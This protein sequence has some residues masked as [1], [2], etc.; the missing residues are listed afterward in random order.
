MKKIW[1]KHPGPAARRSR[2]T[3][4]CSWLLLA[5]PLAHAEG[6]VD[7]IVRRFAQSD[8]EFLRGQTNAPFLPLAWLNV[9]GYEE[10]EFTRPNGEATSVTFRQ[11]T[12]SQ[13]AFLPVPVGKRNAFVIGEWV[14]W[15]DFEVCSAT[16]PDF[17]V[18]SFS[19][20]VGWISQPAP[21]WQVAAFVSPLGHQSSRESDWYWETLGG[22]FARYTSNDNTAWI[23]GAYFDVSPLEDFYTP[24]LG[25]TFIV[26]E[27]WSINA[28]MP[29]PSVT[30]APSKDTLFRLGVA[31]SGSSWSVDGDVQRPRIALAAWNFGL[32]MERRLFGSFW[33]GFEVG[34][35][36]LRGLSLVGGDWQDVD[37]RLD[38]TGFA[39]LT[40]NFR[41]EQVPQR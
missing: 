30:Y 6:F 38:N 11:T 15:T 19:V 2:R 28:V 13:G 25:A 40:F 17:D 9:T 27:Q 4:A 5:T 24:Y 10:G 1:G 29:W 18:L 26:N 3:I 35:S 37:T 23:F 39:W 33:L 22:V 8:F 41:P 21:S 7:T 16:I 34:V 12:L 14:D 31:P 36:G 32:G 20:P